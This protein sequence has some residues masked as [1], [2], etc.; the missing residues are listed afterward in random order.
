MEDE[1]GNCQDRSTSPTSP[2]VSS[3]YSCITDWLGSDLQEL[4]DAG[5]VKFKNG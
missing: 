4:I 5:V 2:S 1:G 3:F